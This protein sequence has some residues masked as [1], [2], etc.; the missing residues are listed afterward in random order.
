VYHVIRRHR[1]RVAYPAFSTSRFSLIQP[2][3]QHN[4]PDRYHHRLKMVYTIT[5][6]ELAKFKKDG[7]LIVPAS[8][9]QLINPE[10]LHKWAYEVRDWPKVKGK[11]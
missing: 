5:D 4:Q 8:K 10:D 11:E 6:E 9:H 7:Y 1:S 2:T 3:N